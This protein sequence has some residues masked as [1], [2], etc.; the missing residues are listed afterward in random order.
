MDEKM[1]TK[2]WL[3]K[4]ISEFYKTKKRWKDYIRSECKDCSRNEAKLRATKFRQTP[5]Y[6]SEERRIKR[7]ELSKEYR[8]K[9]KDK[10]SEKAKTKN[11]NMYYDVRYRLMKLWQSMKRR[12]YNPKSDNYKRYW[13]KWIKIER[14]SFE[15]FYNDMAPSYIEHVNVHWYWR[16]NTQLDRIDPNGNYSKENCRRVTAKE[17]NARNHNKEFNS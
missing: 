7:A 3:I 13:W 4:P 6:Y 14:N 11:K 9:N 16:K 5:E 12:C 17:N 2:C 10:I 1:C 8:K 15:E